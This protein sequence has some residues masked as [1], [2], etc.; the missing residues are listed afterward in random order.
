MQHAA[1]IELG[2]MLRRTYVAVRPRACVDVRRRTQCERGFIG[3]SM[4]IQRAMLHFSKLIPQKKI[5]A[6]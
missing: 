3:S 1:Q 4:T 6:R 2:G 5:N